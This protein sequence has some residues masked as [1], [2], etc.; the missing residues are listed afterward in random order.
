MV[1][2]RHMDYLWALDRAAE[3]VQQLGVAV[4]KED[5]EAA[6]ELS[7]VVIT[8]KTLQAQIEQGLAHPK[9]RKLN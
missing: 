9:N 3:L 7:A 8:L 4:E 5:V 2:V 1:E 6:Q